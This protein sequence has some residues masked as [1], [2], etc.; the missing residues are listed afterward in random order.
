MKNSTLIG[1]VA[2]V[3][4]L[5]GGMWAY[6]SFGPSK[7]GGFAQCLAEKGALFYGAFWC[8]HCQE[9]KAMFGAGARD[10]PYVECSTPDGKGQLPLCIEK[11]V[12]QYPTWMFADGSKQSGVIPLADLA[13]KT[14]CA[15]PE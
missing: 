13:Q 12:E 3:L 5:L 6:R 7:Y 15:L 10:L 2:I 9:Q 14:G 4:V 8:P 1:I 11:G